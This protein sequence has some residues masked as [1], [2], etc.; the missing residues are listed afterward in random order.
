MTQ[1]KMPSGAIV[2]I[3]NS[4][5][6]AYGFD[7]R[8]EAFGDKGLLQTVN[9]CQDTLVRWTA[10]KTEARQPLKHFFLERYDASFYHA[11]GEFHDAVIEGR[12]PSATPEDGRAALAIALAC[13]V[14]SK[15]GRAVAPSYLR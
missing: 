3:N 6:C 4:R 8:V 10:R 12:P 5:N 14:S 2:H 9:H 15:T 11:L 7:Q 1:L 13:T